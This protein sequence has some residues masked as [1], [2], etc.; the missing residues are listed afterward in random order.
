MQF[1]YTTITGERQGEIMGD[2]WY[3]FPAYKPMKPGRYLVTL[4]RPRAGRWVDIRRWNGE[5]WERNDDV[6][7]WMVLPERFGVRHA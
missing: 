5:I 3:S 7:A 4:R 6:S 2:K 1:H